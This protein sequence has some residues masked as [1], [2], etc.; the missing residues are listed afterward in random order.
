[1][2]KLYHLQDLPNQNPTPLANPEIEFLRALGLFN[3]PEIA[4]TIL[5][6]EA[7]REYLEAL[8]ILEPIPQFHQTDIISSGYE[9][10]NNHY[11]VEIGKESINAQDSINT[12]GVLR[13]QIINIFNNRFNFTYGFK[14]RLCLIRKISRTTNYQEGLFEDR[15]F[16]EEADND[17]KDYK[18]VL[19]KNKAVV[20]TAKEDIP[21]IVDELIWDIEN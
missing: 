4:E 14:T 9:L 11:Q 5:S 19:F 7:E 2:K 6:P 16:A 12:L 21:R 17:E 10:L 13:E 18:E 15:K 8:E 1:N 20:V 3:S